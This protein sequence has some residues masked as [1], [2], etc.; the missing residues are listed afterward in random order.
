MIIAVLMVPL[1]GFAA[2]SLDIAATHAEKQQLQTGADAAALAIA[3]DCARKDCGTPADTAQS[4][5]TLNSNSGA[6]VADV[7]PVPTELSGRVT[8]RTSAV[9]QHLFA[10]VL[11]VDSTEL[12]TSATA[13]WGSPTGGT[14]ALPMIFS[15]CDFNKY[16]VDGRPSG[17]EQ[18]IV[19]TPA[20]NCS[21]SVDHSPTYLPGGFGWLQTDLKKSCNA[22]TRIGTKAS[23]EPGNTAKHCDLSTIRNRTILVPIF[24][25]A[26]PAETGGQ[27]RGAWYKVYGYAAFTVTGYNFSGQ[28]WEPPC[29]K[30]LRCIS[31]YFTTILQADP[32]F[33]YGP[34]GPDLG[35][36][37]VVLLPD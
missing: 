17:R 16:S 10:P 24:D 21:G 18:V 20:G 6:A 22:T 3:Q 34:G 14:S 26:D 13:G 28:S 36:A 33:D 35:A 4:L 8:V 19:T 9:R 12:T 32:D 1:L 5:A 30:N 27:G 11:G 2:L 31:G 37:A 25:D 23:S 29:A 15:L 7:D